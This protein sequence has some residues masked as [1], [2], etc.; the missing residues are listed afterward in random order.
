MSPRDQIVF[1]S[2]E[3]DLP[4]DMSALRKA[5]CTVGP[6]Q[7]TSPVDDISHL[8]SGSASRSRGHENIG[9]CDNQIVTLSSC[10]TAVHTRPFCVPASGVGAVSQ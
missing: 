10:H 1:V 6:K 7:A 8:S 9:A 4:V 3:K 2:E 5:V